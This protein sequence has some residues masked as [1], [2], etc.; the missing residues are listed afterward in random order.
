MSL[1]N[2]EQFN[3]FSFLIFFITRKMNRTKP[4]NLPGFVCRSGKDSKDQTISYLSIPFFLHE[5]IFVLNLM[6]SLALIFK[7]K[8]KTKRHWKMFLTKVLDSLYFFTFMGISHE[9]RLRKLYIESL[10]SFKTW[11]GKTEKPDPK[12]YTASLAFLN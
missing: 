12:H 3:N 1:K 11:I 8:K 2:L 9:I 7:K 6:F 10:E 5:H 4:D